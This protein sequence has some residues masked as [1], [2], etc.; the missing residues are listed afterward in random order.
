M[1]EKLGGL[2]GWFLI[3]A[4]AG[5]I[6]NYCLKFVNKRFSKRIAASPAGKKIMKNL[7]NIFVRNH[8]YVGFSAA[9]LLLAHFT[10]Q[11]IRFGI[12]ITGCIAAIIMI[13]Q[14]FSGAYANKKKLP[15]KGAW[16]AV[17]RATAVL[18]I[19]G[20]AI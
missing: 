10:I 20:I 16:F 11:Y 1:V 8:K 12:N 19:F 7:M 15:R 3:L 17:H 14:V 13:F 18:I 2:F 4:F 9:V 5:T 6:M